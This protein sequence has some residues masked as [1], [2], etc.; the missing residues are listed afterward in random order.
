[1][2]TIL[3]ELQRLKG[4]KRTGWALR[5]QPSDTESVAAHSF[6][7][8]VTAMLLA[9]ELVARGLTLDRERILRMALL[10]DWAEARLGDLPRTAARY[11]DAQTRK[12]A[13]AAAFA[14][15]ATGAGAADAYYKDLHHEYEQRS[16][17]EARLVKAADVIDLL[18]QAL[19]MEQAGAH[20]LD[21]FWEVVTEDT[22]SLSGLAADVVQG[23]L[24]LLVEAR[25]VTHCS[26]GG[27]AG[28]AES[29]QIG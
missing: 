29:D 10:H 18:V 4:L 5:G 27:S 21:E 2:L 19:A 24:A 23:L 16:S 6:G 7:V 20:G 8:A 26:V 11:L 28:H 12:R 17:L 3:L 13:D 15:I 9:D 25:R 22:F 1:M 14:D